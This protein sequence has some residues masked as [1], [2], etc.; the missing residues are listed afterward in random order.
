M[1]KC[2]LIVAISG[3]AG[4]S[5]VEPGAS[6]AA[7]LRRAFGKKIHI[8]ALAY[9]PLSNTLYTEGLVDEAY[10]MQAL[11]DVNTHYLD[12]K[13]VF[14]LCRPDI[15]LPCLELEVKYLSYFY[16]QFR[17]T[18]PKMLVPDT[19]YFEQVSKLELHYFCNN[20]LLP[21]PRTLVVHNA[22]EWAYVINAAVFPCL[23]K[24]PI[25][26]AELVH[27]FGQA[28]KAAQL[29]SNGWKQPILIQDYV[30]GDQYMV[31]ALFDA[32]GKVIQTVMAKKHVVNPLGK[33]A[34]S[35]T[36]HDE[37]L[38]QAARRVLDHLI[39]SGPLELEFIKAADGHYYLFEINP[40]F[41]SWMDI[42][43]TLGTN[44]PALLLHHLQGDIL[45]PL[46]QKYG[47]VLIR[48]TDECCV[49]VTTFEQFQ[50]QGMLDT[51][52]VEMSVVKSNGS[53]AA[54]SILITGASSHHLPMPGASV[55][56]ALRYAKIKMRLVYWAESYQDTGC[57]RPDLFDDIVQMP[58]KLHPQQLLEEIIRM[59]RRQK[60][61]A[62]IPTLD[63][64]IEWFEQ[65]ADTLKQ[66]GISV[67]LPSARALK[68]AYHFPFMSQKT[69]VSFPP[70]MMVKNGVEVKKALS[71]LGFPLVLKI[72][73]PKRSCLQIA[74]TVVE[75]EALSAIVEGVEPGSYILQKYIE[76]EHFA[77]CGVAIEK[78]KLAESVVIKAMQTCRYGKIW[79]A[80]TLEGETAQ[81]FVKVLENIVA[82]LKWEGPI[83][84]D[85]IRDKYHETIFCIDVNPR[86][87]SWIFYASQVNP[88]LLG[89][90]LKKLLGTG[91]VVSEETHVPSFYVRFPRSYLSNVQT[92]GKLLSGKEVNYG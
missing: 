39:W 78:G 85:C 46:N 90:Y 80:S 91:D 13:R 92:L 42:G 1:K 4:T 67:I 58:E 81:P 87:P 11:S 47:E 40:R 24:S 69:K 64:H 84:I 7:G 48:D 27:T 12:L 82:E 31:A 2:K 50:R 8:V 88:R 71:Q 28:Y 74:Q 41:P 65:I 62:I 30:A 52:S 16:K 9:S 72:L 36:I 33:S 76:G 77:V 63:R 86:F 79:I 49:P 83:E 20:H 22:I 26:G 34:I 14:A 21:M 43:Q 32:D 73:G 60:I 53:V 51:L 37:G 55:A 23:I 18:G 5:V 57:Y 59:Q 54:N 45:P 68:C 29:F 19:V 10:L 61:K 6:V 70:S 66:H 35:L 15:Y 75:V 89:K 25:N 44:L 17:R 3:F 38:N 56:K